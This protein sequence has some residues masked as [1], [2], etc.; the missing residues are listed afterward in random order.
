MDVLQQIFTPPPPAQD[1][2]ESCPKPIKPF[3][4]MGALALTLVTATLMNIFLRYIYIS[5]G[6]TGAKVATIAFGLIFYGL[7]ICFYIALALRHQKRSEPII[8]PGMLEIALTV[9]FQVL[10]MAGTFYG[11]VKL[12]K[13]VPIVH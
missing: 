7:C 3:S 6:I 12:L 9:F 11:A 5:T 2:G 8:Y 13:A 10:L 4:S 1:S